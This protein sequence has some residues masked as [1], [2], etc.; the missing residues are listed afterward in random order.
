VTSSY[1][2]EIIPG[3]I[4]IGALDFDAD[5]FSGFKQNA[6]RTDFD[7]EFVNLIGLE[8]LPLGVQV[9]GLPGLG[10]G[11]VEFSLRSAEPATRQKSASAIGVEMP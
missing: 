10:R 5:A 11:R 7:I 2:L 3:D 1:Q 6:V 8:R 9:D 4:I